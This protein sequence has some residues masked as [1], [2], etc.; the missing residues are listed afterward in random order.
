[1]N[2]LIELLGFEAV[3]KLCNA[4]AGCSLYIP[5]GKALK[6]AQR[7]QLIKA[8]RLEGAEIKAIAIKYQLTTR[9]IF[10]ILKWSASPAN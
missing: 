8:D 6:L 2:E 5:T 10:T 1:M 4:Y 9:Q 7:K 3:L